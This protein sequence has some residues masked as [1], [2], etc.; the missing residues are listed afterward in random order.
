ME[1]GQQVIANIHIRTREGIIFRGSKGV[2]QSQTKDLLD[3]QLILVEWNFNNGHLLS[4]SFPSEIQIVI[5]E[6]YEQ[7]DEE[8]KIPF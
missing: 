2:V 3:R 6:E 7:E 5:P 4:Y 8:L 1:K